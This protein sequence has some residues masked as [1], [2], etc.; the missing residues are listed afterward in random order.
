[1]DKSTFESKYIK[2]LTKSSQMLFNSGVITD[3][4]HND[5]LRKIG[6]KTSFGVTLMDAL[7]SVGWWR[8]S[9]SELIKSKIAIEVNGEHY[10]LCDVN[11]HTHYVSLTKM[12][13]TC[14]HDNVKVIDN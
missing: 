12:S 5:N 7:V 9:A 2:S 13:S 8:T 10:I 14:H 3:A 1:M 11:G 4:Q 6:N